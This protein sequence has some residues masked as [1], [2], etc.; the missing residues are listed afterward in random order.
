VTTSTVSLLADQLRA[1]HR[2]F[3]AAMHSGALTS[4]E[5]LGSRLLELG[6]VPPCEALQVWAHDFCVALGR[7][8]VQS[9]DLVACALSFEQELSGK[10]DRAVLILGEL[11]SAQGRLTQAEF[12]EAAAELGSEP[13][14]ETL[15][16]VLQRW[17]FR[18]A[19]WGGPILG[20]MRD[21][22][23]RLEVRHG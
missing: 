4:F 14:A 11:L 20:W 23:D 2:L 5:V 21:L 18:G 15:C 8:P 19:A 6:T 17:I 22:R 12:N 7:P 9:A 1:A 10:A 3:E 13:T 16:A